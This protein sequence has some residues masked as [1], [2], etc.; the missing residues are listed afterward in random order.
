SPHFVHSSSS[1]YTPTSVFLMYRLLSCS[2]T[3]TPTSSFFTSFLSSATFTLLD[4][5]GCH[6]QVLPL[7]LF[8]EGGLDQYH[9]VSDL[10]HELCNLVQRPGDGGLLEGTQDDLAL[11]FGD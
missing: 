7:L 1:I 10:L 9:K 3:Y 2:F 5:L 8:F 4:N 6:T 11:P